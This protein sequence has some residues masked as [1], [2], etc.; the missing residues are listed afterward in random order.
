MKH[1]IQETLTSIV[2]NFKNE[3]LLPAET[4]TRIMVENTKDKKKWWLRYQSSYAS[5]ET[6]ENE[7]YRNS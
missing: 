6:D 1:I 4:T 5:C 2:D 3:G 7:T